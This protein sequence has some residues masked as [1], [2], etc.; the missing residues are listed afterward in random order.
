MLILSPWIAS[1]ALATL[2]WQQAPPPPPQADQHAAEA[3]PTEPPEPRGV[4]LRTDGA[5]AGYTLLAPLMDNRT[6]LL[7]LDGQ[8]VHQW[9]HELPPGNSVY[10]MPD[11][12]LFRASRPA[13]NPTFKGGGEGGILEEYSWE[14]E[15]LWQYEWN[16]AS[17]LMHHDFEVLP[18]GNLLFIAWEEIDRETA[19]AHGKDPELLG[20]GALWPDVIVEVQPTRPSGGKVV[21]EWHTW[22][23]IIQDRLPDGPA[24]GEVWEDP[25]RVDINGEG[26]KQEMSEDERKRLVELGYLSADSDQRPAVSGQADWMHSNGIDYDAERDLII[27]SVRRFNELWVIDHSTSTAEARTDKGGNY[28]H[29]GRL[30]Y[31]WGNPMAYGRGTLEHRQLFLQHDTQFIDPGLPGAGNILVYNNGRG[32]PGDQPWS[33]VDEIQFADFKPGSDW[34]D[35]DGHLLPESPKWTYGSKENPEFYS[36]FISGAQRLPNGSTLICEGAEGRVFEVQPSGEVVWDYLSPWG[37]SAIKT[38]GSRDTQP[39]DAD[40]SDRP[41]RADPPKKRRRG[42]GIP[43]VA[44]F[45]ATRYA[46]DFAAFAERKLVPL[47]PQPSISV[48]GKK[49]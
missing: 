2:G 7:D 24:Y 16:D 12:R 25:S 32:R 39:A 35:D 4:K 33:T 6:Y 19:L 13:N 21:W 27:M 17:K 34:F 41:D 3:E 11:G 44:L 42:G 45:R 36:S 30:V 38:P 43:P 10:L 40:R 31:R 14:G 26:E 18:N 22:D 47:H 5:F 49:D 15:L 48:A 46:A 29:G 23:H 20:D 9:K 1:I 28:G 37:D 8:V